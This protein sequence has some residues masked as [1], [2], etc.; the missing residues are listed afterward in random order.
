MQYFFNTESGRI[1]NLDD[2]RKDFEL[3]HS[4]YETFDNFLTACMYYN[5]GALIP[6]RMHIQRLESQLKRADEL[7]DDE[8]KEKV[9]EIEYLR[10]LEK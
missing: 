7:D 8:R 2:V 10:R 5:N 4:E 6:L 9:K 3:F 1:E